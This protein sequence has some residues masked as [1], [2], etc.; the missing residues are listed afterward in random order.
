MPDGTRLRLFSAP[1]AAFAA[2]NGGWKQEVEEKEGKKGA[3]SN[4]MP[5]IAPEGRCIRTTYRPPTYKQR[6]PAIQTTD[7]CKQ[8]THHTQPTTIA[9]HPTCGHTLQQ[10][11]YEKQPGRRTT[12]GRL[13]RETFYRHSPNHHFKHSSYLKHSSYAKERPPDPRGQLSRL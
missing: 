12:D 6:F 5:N 2:Q 9:D 1:A 13:A 8:N 3:G 10:T 7:S 4:I 11:R